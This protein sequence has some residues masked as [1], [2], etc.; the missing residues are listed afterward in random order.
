[1]DYAGVMAQCSSF[2][3]RFSWCQL[4]CS[5]VKSV[6]T[7]SYNLST[8]RDS[9]LNRNSSQTTVSHPAT[10]RIPFIYCLELKTLQKQHPPHKYINIVIHNVLIVIFN[11]NVVILNSSIHHSIQHCIISPR[12][13]Q[14]PRQIKST[15]KN[16]FNKTY[17]FIKKYFLYIS[18]GQWYLKSAV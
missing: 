6:V 8:L 12:N 2:V 17:K 10:N 4:F 1:M 16:S 5:G 3:L 7:T 15:Y 11:T 18:K 14:Q 13:K 9:T